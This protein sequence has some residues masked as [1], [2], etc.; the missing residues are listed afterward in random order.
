MVT[1]AEMGLRLNRM[2][3]YVPP[4]AEQSVKKL[5]DLAK[6]T[7]IRLNRVRIPRKKPVKWGGKVQLLNGGDKPQAKFTPSPRGMASLVEQ[8]SHASGW[9]EGSRHSGSS[10]KGRESRFLKGKATGGDNRAV[11]NIPGI[12]YRRFVVHPR[13]GPIAHPL[14]DTALALSPGSVLVLTETVMKPL[15]RAFLGG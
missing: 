6:T 12:G 10:R 14:A 3:N 1:V 11:L 4:A 15:G 7:Y 8:G 9:F 5:G 13:V 2:S